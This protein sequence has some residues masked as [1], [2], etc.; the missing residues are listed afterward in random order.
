MSA[1]LEKTPNAYASAGKLGT[2]RINTSGAMYASVPTM[3]CFWNPPEGAEACVFACVLS[4]RYLPATAF[5][6]A[7]SSEYTAACR[8]ARSAASSSA[9]PKSHSRATQSAP[10]S[11]LLG[12]R[13]RWTYPREWTYAIAAATCA[14]RVTTADALGRHPRSWINDATEPFSWKGKRR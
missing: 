2:R 4:E 5:P 1:S 13:S 6:S 10:R 8:D 3:C 14:R 9:R 11:T 7:S 12:L